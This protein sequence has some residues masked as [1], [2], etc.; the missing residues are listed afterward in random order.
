MLQSSRS[1]EEY[2]AELCCFVK[3]E[4][5]GGSRAN[6]TNMKTWGE[7]LIQILPVKMRDAR[8]AESIDGEGLSLEIE[9]VVLGWKDTQRLVQHAQSRKRREAA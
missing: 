4:A 1:L 5:L 7:I 8:E 6:K 3:K 2:V 9:R